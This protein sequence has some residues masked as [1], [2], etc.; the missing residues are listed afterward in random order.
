MTGASIEFQCASCGKLLKVAANGAGKAVRCPGCGQSIVVPA[1]PS[2]PASIPQITQR[3]EITA[4]TYKGSLPASRSYPVLTLIAMMCRAMAV[5]VVAMAGV[6]I[7][8]GYKVA[9]A[10]PDNSRIG[11]VAA[12]LA[13]GFVAILL[14]LM[15]IMVA[16]MIM[17][18]VHIQ[19]NT[20]AAAH[21]SRRAG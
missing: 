12:V 16:E 4:A 5:L 10:Q 14:A 13:V 9:A 11:M 7:I 8:V 19:A 18:A 1:A 2:Q 17:L 21:A 15:L 20:L 6:G 3:P